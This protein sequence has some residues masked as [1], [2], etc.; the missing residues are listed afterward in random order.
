M[1]T[2]VIIGKERP[3]DSAAIPLVNGKAFGQNGEA[4]LVDRLR[5]NVKAVLCYPWR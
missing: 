1:A 5:D 3:E 4:D 2:E